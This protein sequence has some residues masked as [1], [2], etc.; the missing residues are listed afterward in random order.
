MCRPLLGRRGAYN[1][2]FYPYAARLLEPPAIDE[3]SID[4]LTR[5]FVRF[6]PIGESSQSLLS[7][8]CGH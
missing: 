6:P 5:E 2:P 4:W 7:P 8:H 1:L 3:G